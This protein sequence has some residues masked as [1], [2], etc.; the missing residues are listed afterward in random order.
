MID[1]H[2]HI[3]PG[4][5]D[6]A[7]DLDESVAM[8]RLA[9]GAGTTDIV[10]TPHSDLEYTY[11]LETVE[12]KIAEL[13]AAAGGA[14]RIHRGCDFHMAYENIHDALE[15]PSRYTINGKKYL[16]I[17]FSELLIPQTTEE[18][19]RRMFEAGIVPVVTHPERNSL[20]RNHSPRLETWVQS[21][22]CLQ[23]TAHSFF[24]KF[25]ERAKRFSDDLLSRG[26]VHVVASD[27]HDTAYRP[28][29][30][31]EA[32]QYIENRCGRETADLLCVKNP[33]AML[34]GEPIRHPHPAPPRARKWYRFWR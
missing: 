7:R 12:Q 22:C 8:V 27:A 3:L 16:L 30:L 10:A 15:N 32:Y 26:L 29:R 2:S 1:I 25:G 34:S 6:G 23:V 13:T 18:V 11:D 28:P 17:E 31:D 33:S 14:V 9:A 19:L 21:G 20:L 24:G 5:D 4:L